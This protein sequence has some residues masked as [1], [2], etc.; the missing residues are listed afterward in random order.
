MQVIISDT[1]PCCPKNWDFWWHPLRKELWLFDGSWHAVLQDVVVPEVDIKKLLGQA[2]L[3]PSALVQK[4]SDRYER[5]LITNE[6]T[7]N[8][9]SLVTSGGVANAIELLS[10]S[11]SDIN[12]KVN[13]VWKDVVRKD[14]VKNSITWI[15]SADE[16]PNTKAV[17]DYIVSNAYTWDGSLHVNWKVISVKDATKQNKWVIKISTMEDYDSMSPN[18]ATSPE[19]IKPL[20]DTINRNISE[21]TEKLDSLLNKVSGLETKIKDLESKQNQ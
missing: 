11:L 15:G 5:V 21:L 18:T 16:I 8:S 9:G 17:V 10:S 4:S 3:S 6:V 19:L 14:S 7:K 20:I 12:S 13:D 2:Q 1:K